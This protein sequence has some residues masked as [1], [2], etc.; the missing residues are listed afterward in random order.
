MILRNAEL[1]VSSWKTG[2]AANPGEV[3]SHIIFN[4]KEPRSLAMKNCWAAG[5][6]VSVILHIIM[7]FITIAGDLSSKHALGIL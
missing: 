3:S 2:R 1:C 4:F 5:G 7:D 6:L